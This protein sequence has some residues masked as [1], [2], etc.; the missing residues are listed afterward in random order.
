MRTIKEVIFKQEVLS[1]KAKNKVLR[2]TLKFVKKRLKEDVKIPA[3]LKVKN[4]CISDKEKFYVQK[5]ILLKAENDILNQA[6]KFVNQRVNYNLEFYSSK[7]CDSL[8]IETSS[9]YDKLLECKK[10]L[11]KILPNETVILKNCKSL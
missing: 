10:E 9:Y 5:K 1:L 11:L 4:R 7:F 3:S 6:L 2:R 8:D